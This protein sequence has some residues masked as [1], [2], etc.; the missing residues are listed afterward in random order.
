MQHHA[1]TKNNSE[2]KL[3]TDLRSSIVMLFI[4]TVILG[5]LFFKVVFNPNA[6]ASSLLME[7]IPFIACSVMGVSLRSN[8]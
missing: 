8:D 2:K 3:R 7:F 6:H 5:H 4:A 1:D